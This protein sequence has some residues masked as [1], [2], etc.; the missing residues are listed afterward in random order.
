MLLLTLLAFMLWLQVNWPLRCAEAFAVLLVGL[1]ALALYS[2][3]AR[4]TRGEAQDGSV[5]PG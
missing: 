4:S 5:A 3:I 1:A 2:Y